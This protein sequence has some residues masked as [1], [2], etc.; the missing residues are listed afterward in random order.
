[1]FLCG[2]SP[3]ETALMINRQRMVKEAAEQM[4]ADRRARQMRKSRLASRIMHTVW[5]MVGIIA[6]AYCLYAYAVW[7]GRL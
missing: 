5:L 7:S 2:D 4:R 1:M 6:A 3:Q